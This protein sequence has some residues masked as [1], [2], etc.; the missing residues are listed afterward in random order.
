MTRAIIGPGANASKW[1]RDTQGGAG[2]GGIVSNV[3][4]IGRIGISSERIMA[5]GAEG[6]GR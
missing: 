4:A 2:W 5:G 1:E 3:L 6:V